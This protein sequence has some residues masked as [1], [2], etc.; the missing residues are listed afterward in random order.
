VFDTALHQRPAWL[1]LEVDDDE[2]VS[3]DQ[4]LA[5]VIVTMAADFQT[6]R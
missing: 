1:A 4:H 3:A 5:E 6:G 2:V